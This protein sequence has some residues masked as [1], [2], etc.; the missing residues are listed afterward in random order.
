VKE[1]PQF[2]EAPEMYEVWRDKRERVTTIEID[3]GAEK[4]A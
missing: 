2:E 3:P 1:R 4:A